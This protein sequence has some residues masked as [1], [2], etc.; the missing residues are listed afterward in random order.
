VNIRGIL[1]APIRWLLL[2][3]ARRIERAHPWPDLPHGTYGAEMRS[4]AAKLR[5]LAESIG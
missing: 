1:F 4:F 2:R 5:E 3:K